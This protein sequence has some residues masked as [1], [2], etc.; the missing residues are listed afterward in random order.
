[1][2][3]H[4]TIPTILRF[5]F[6]LIALSFACPISTILPKSRHTGALQYAMRVSIGTINV[7]FD[8]SVFLKISQLVVHWSGFS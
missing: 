6:V 1:L 3:F 7:H 2:F 8:M 5:S 4:R